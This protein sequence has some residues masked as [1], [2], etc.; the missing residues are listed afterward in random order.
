MLNKL[1]MACQIKRDNNNNIIEVLAPNGKPSMLYDTLKSKLNNFK[2]KQVVVMDD[3]VSLVVNS[4]Y[5]QNKNNE[6]LALAAWSK[7]YTKEFINSF[8]DWKTKKLPNTDINGEPDVDSL[9]DVRTVNEQN[10]TAETVR[11]L[12]YMMQGK[13]DTN[14]K[15]TNDKD[16]LFISRIEDNQVTVNLANVTP[17]TNIYDVF[18]HVILASVKKNNLTL[19]NNL[20]DVTKTNQKVKN[21]DYR[22]KLSKG[23]F[24]TTLDKNQAA[25]A[26][27][28]LDYVLGKTTEKP[29]YVSGI[30]YVRF[31]D[32]ELYTYKSALNLEYDQSGIKLDIKETTNKLQSI[33]NEATERYLYSDSVSA[34]IQEESMLELLN[35]YNSNQLEDNAEIRLA[36]ELLKEVKSF[37]QKILP[38]KDLNQLP[39]NLTVNDI[40]GL[41]FQKNQVKPGV[42]ELFESDTELANQVYETLGFKST[43]AVPDKEIEFFL[44]DEK[45]KI[46]L[47]DITLEEEGDIDLNVQN[48]T[49]TFIITAKDKKLGFIQVQRKDDNTVKIALSGLFKG[50][51][52]IKKSIIEKV[53][54]LINNI[55][56]SKKINIS[57]TRTL[58][59]VNVGK[60]IGKITYEILAVKLKENY[61][62]DLVS[63]TT[64]SDYAENLWKSFER[65]GKAI[66]VGDPDT[67]YR[68]QYYYKFI[69][70][71]TITPQQ[72]QQ[73]Q[74]LYSQY[75]NTIFPNSK[76]KDI[77]YHGTNKDFSEFVSGKGFWGN[78]FYVTTEKGYANSI[79][80][81]RARQEPGTSKII[82]PLLINANNI[83]FEEDA[84]AIDEFP[85]DIDTILTNIEGGGKIIYAVKNPEQI[86]TLGSKKDIEGFKKF[87]KDTIDVSGMSSILNP[88]NT[89][90]WT[91]VE[92]NCPKL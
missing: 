43:I 16:R 34:T 39:E 65:K 56:K 38:Q 32:G 90:N 69:V 48:K 87:V 30:G 67:K 74:Q 91:N 27:K 1:T 49:N 46:N 17:N 77:V 26:Q 47:K 13:I 25:R 6:E 31:K 50:K 20:I 81:S 75:L 44:R 55:F 4:E 62:K 7:A 24:H 92:N 61:G 35:L 89:N 80:A 54:E 11:E 5:I 3:Y 15:L 14:Y 8:G 85:K 51:E 22:Y 41:L 76:V 66:R 63:D 21:K 29:P 59:K 82:K 84:Y 52:V 71:N 79:A 23:G 36:K 58:E 45:L 88:I 19:Y 73:A 83:E 10:L 72:E 37:I 64:R 78:A 28:N 70:D 2:F 12:S 68:W 40:I 57:S 42:E 18:G 53:L 9:F 86:H 60:G 33:I